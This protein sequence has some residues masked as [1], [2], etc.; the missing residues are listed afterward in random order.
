MVDLQ[1]SGQ[2]TAE[3]AETLIREFGSPLFVYDAE[4][5]KRQYDRLSRAFR[6]CAMRIHFAGKSLP[7]ISIWRYLEQLGSGFDAV[8]IQEVELALRAGFPKQRILFTPN[9]VGIEEYEAAIALGV[10]IQVDNLSILEELG[11]RYGHSVSV[12]V[13]LNPHI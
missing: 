5:I 10:R 1:A 7:N 13:R 4:I 8:S 2:M 6:R 3:R 9:S 11:A 12:G